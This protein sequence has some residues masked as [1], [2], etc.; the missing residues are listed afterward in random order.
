MTA[1]DTTA[2]NM[3]CVDVDNDIV[4]HDMGDMVAIDVVIDGEWRRLTM[5]KFTY[6]DMI[7]SF[8]PWS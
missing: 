4:A 5:T 2:S 3:K 1:Q 7:E 6:V 8:D